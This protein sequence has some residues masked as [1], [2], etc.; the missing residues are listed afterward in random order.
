LCLS[1]GEADSSTPPQIN[2][3][4]LVGILD[5]AVLQGDLAIE[6]GRDAED[7]CALNLRLDG[8]RIDDGAA[9]DREDDPPDT[10]HSVPQH[11]DLSDVREIGPK[12]ELRQRMEQSL[13]LLDLLDN[14]RI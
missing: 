5:T 3:A 13:K 11:F 1:A 4:D 7:D 12:D 14:F 2:S 9:I 8:I 10:N 6:R